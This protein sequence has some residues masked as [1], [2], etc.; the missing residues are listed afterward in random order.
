MIDIAETSSSVV[1]GAVKGV[2]LKSNMKNILYIALPQ[3]HVLLLIIG[4]AQQS[5]QIIKNW[6]ELFLR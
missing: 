3:K 2:S 6:I 4:S 1:A 5:N